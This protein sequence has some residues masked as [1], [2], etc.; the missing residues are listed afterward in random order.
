MHTLMLRAPLLASPRLAWYVRFF[1]PWTGPEL[2]SDEL[3][4]DKSLASLGLCGDRFT[5][6]LNWQKAPPPHM[7]NA[8]ELLSLIHI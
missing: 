5:L 3:P 1:V 6:L 7:L 8:V 4:A 2:Y